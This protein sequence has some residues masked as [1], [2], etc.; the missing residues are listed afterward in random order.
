MSVIVWGGGGKKTS[1]LQG[2]LARLQGKEVP[3]IRHYT[4]GKK[5]LFRNLKEILSIY[6]EEGV[7]RGEDRPPSPV[8]REK[9]TC[10]PLLQKKPALRAQKGDSGAEEEG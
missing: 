1:L 3:N 5:S 2:D 4:G 10:P 7:S 6:N 8:K 9:G